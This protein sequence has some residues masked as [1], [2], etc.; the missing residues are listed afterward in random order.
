MNDG[1][2]DSKIIGNVNIWEF[3][4]MSDGWKK[5]ERKQGIRPPHF[6]VAL[7]RLLGI[8]EQYTMSCVW[9]FTDTGRKDG[10]NWLLAPTGFY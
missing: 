4:N 10:R 9:R 3:P 7:P 5:E 8:I 6:G 1:L 2:C